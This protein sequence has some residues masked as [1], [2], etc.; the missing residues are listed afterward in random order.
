[1]GSATHFIFISVMLLLWP[2][3]PGAG[4]LLLQIE[5]WLEALWLGWD[6][7]RD[8]WWGRFHTLLSPVSYRLALSQTR[9]F[10]AYS[11][12][13]QLASQ[14][15]HKPFASK[16]DQVEFINLHLPS[17]ISCHLATPSCQFYSLASHMLTDGQCLQQH[18]FSNAE[19]P[20]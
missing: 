13:Q 12:C 7:D 9:C 20:T 3:G 19:R 5:I 2:Q 18:L 11:E 4:S 6:V 17:S 1:M 14:F 15:P 8:W 10:F 16:E